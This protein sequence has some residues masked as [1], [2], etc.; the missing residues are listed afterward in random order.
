MLDRMTFVNHVNERI[1]FGANGL[2]IKAND[3]RDYSWGYTTVGNGVGQ[4][5][6]DFVEKTIP[7]LILSD[8]DTAMALK[9]RLCEVGEKDV[10]AKEPGKLCIGDGYLQCYIIGNRKSEYLT[11]EKMLVGEITILAPKALWI[12]EKTKQFTSVEEAA[13]EGKGYPHAFPYNYSYDGASNM[14]YNEHYAPSDFVMT[15]YGA[16]IKPAIY[17]NDHKYSVDVTLAEGEYLVIDSKKK[18]I[19]RKRTDGAIDNLFRYRDTESY[20]FE[21]IQPGQCEMSWS[22]QFGFDLTI[23]TERGEPKW[24]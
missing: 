2:Y 18:T 14:M 20:I 22:G 1:E 7:Y 3:I 5:T 11:D 16:A 4:F 24:T 12:Y 10:L 17:I 23:I 19:T 21:K 15:I 9:N 6:K 8:Y 13:G